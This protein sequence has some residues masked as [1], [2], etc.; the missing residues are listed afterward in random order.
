MGKD[1]ELIIDQNFCF[2]AEKHN[3]LLKYLKTT[4]DDGGKDFEDVKIALEGYLEGNFYNRVYQ[5]PDGSLL[6]ELD[7][8]EDFESVWT[9]ESRNTGIWKLKDF[10]RDHSFIEHR[11]GDGGHERIYVF[12][13]KIYAQQ[14]EVVFP[15]MKGKE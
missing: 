2:P 10:M 8:R 15:K 4:F 12:K 3:E 14:G 5:N 1:C 13:G 6:V 9:D 7:C 11:D